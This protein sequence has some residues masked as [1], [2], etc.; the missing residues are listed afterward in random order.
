MFTQ[1]QPPAVRWSSI[2]AVMG[3]LLC[4]AFPAQSRDKLSSSQAAAQVQSQYGGQ[5][6]GIQ[7]LR[8]NNRDAYRVK[9]LLPSERVRVILIDAY[10]GRSLKSKKNGKGKKP[11][12]NR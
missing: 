12:K 7:S 6:L 4:L 8:L 9:V 1:R 11:Q 2:F 3:L 10:T 5:V